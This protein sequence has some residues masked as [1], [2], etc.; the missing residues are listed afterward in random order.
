MTAS[1]ATGTFP[2]HIHNNSKAQTQCPPLPP[3]SVFIIRSPA[4][5][6][7][8]FTRNPENTN[9]TN[10]GALQ[11]QTLADT[12]VTVLMD[13][14][15]PYVSADDIPEP[16]EIHLQQHSRASTSLYGRG[17]QLSS[18]PRKRYLMRVSPTASIP[19]HR[20][21]VC[22]SEEQRSLSRLFW[23]SWHSRE[24]PCSEGAIQGASLSPPQ[25]A[26]HVETHRAQTFTHLDC[27]SQRSVL[28][29]QT[30]VALQE[31]VPHGDSLCPALCQSRA[32]KRQRS[33]VR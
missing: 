24:E 32:V 18:A 25:A 22:D 6:L 11:I 30:A 21:R 17:V 10:P 28:V 8:T 14:G 5:A 33:A 9:A 7:C 2:I 13:V 23:F 31:T 4:A 15:G 1:V 26:F 16:A 20:R 27:C 29:W 3:R 19:L 12:V